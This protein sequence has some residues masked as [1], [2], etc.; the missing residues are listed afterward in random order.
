MS[1]S[2]TGQAVVILTTTGDEESARALSRALVEEGL[3]ACVSRHAVKS[4]FRWDSTGA[5]IP[6]SEMRVCEEDEVL[7]VI[8]TA[9]AC[10]TQLERR[11]AEIHPYDVPEIV[12]IVPQHVGEKYLSW[13][14]AACAA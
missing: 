4:V 6:V 8:K 14:L 5:G 9:A 1:S 3:C 2:E 11:L 13:L 7:L 12:R 10:A